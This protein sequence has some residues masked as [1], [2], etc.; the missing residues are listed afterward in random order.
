MELTPARGASTAKDPALERRNCRCRSAGASTT[1]IVRP[2][3]VRQAVP[4]R[5]EGLRVCSPQGGSGGD[6]GGSA[7]VRVTWRCK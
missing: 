4:S 7:A 1:G 6:A 3:V 2:P 5:V